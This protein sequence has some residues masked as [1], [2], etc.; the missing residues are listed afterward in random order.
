LG[1]SDE[2]L[3]QTLAELPEYSGESQDNILRDIISAKMRM[4]FSIKYD[5][6]L[7]VVEAGVSLNTRDHAAGGVSFRGDKALT[8]GWFLAAKI[9]GTWEIVQNVND[10]WSIICQVIEPYDF[11]GE[12]VPTCYDQLTMGVVAR[13]GPGSSE[14]SMDQ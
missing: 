8:G 14:S 6:P 9:N 3:L 4:L 7:E 2:D 13:T 11:P 1:L 5:K 10:S 12:I